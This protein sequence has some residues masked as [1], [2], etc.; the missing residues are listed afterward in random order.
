MEYLSYAPWKGR[1]KAEEQRAKG[2]WFLS[3]DKSVW[4]VLKLLIC[5][6]E[7]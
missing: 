3:S 6:V 1:L 7:K 2:R 5:H 4:M